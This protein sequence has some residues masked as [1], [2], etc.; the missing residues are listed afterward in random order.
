MN[1]QPFSFSSSVPCHLLLVKLGGVCLEG[2]KLGGSM[3]Y[4]I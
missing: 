1:H 3:A 2:L 4:L